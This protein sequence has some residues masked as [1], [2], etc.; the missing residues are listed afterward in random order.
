MI[1]VGVGVAAIATG[2]LS[3]RGASEDCGAPA[4]AVCD[5]GARSKVSGWTLIGG[6]AALGIVGGVMFVS[7]GTGEEPARH[8]FVIS[9]RGSF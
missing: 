4:G 1:L 9:L 2:A 6:G 5:K 8:A 7:G 3:L